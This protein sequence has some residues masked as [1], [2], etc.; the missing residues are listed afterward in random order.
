MLPEG[1]SGTGELEQGWVAK[2]QQM[3]GLQPVDLLCIVGMEA[4]IPGSP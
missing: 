2:P 4:G 1:I 3:E